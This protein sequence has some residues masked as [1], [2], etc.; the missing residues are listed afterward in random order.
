VDYDFE[1]E[2]KSMTIET[3]NGLIILTLEKDY[4]EGKV[5]PLLSLLDND[6]NIIISKTISLASL[7]KHK[8]YNWGR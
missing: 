8:P 4:R 3:T 5:N 7:E 1:S 2:D 6:G